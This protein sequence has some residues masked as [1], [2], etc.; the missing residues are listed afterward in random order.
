MKKTIVPGILWGGC[1]ILLLFFGGEQAF[2]RFLLEDDRPSAPADRKDDAAPKDQPQKSEFPPHVAIGI[3]AERIPNV[4]G[5][6]RITWQ[7]DPGATE[8]FIVGRAMEITNTKDKAL[9]AQSIKVVPAAGVNAVIDSNLQPGQYYYVVLSKDRVMSRNIEIYPDVNYTTAPVI[10]EK[11]VEYVQARSYPDQ[12]TLIHGQIINGTQV[13]LTWKAAEESGVV[14]TVYRGE[15]PLNTAE[16]INNAQKLAVITDRR[17]SFIDKTITTTGTYYY[18]VTTRDITGREDLRLVPD[19]SYLT[20]GVY[21]TFKSQVTVSALSAN[22]REG[23]TVELAWKGV[24]S[25]SHRY[26]I[27]RY[28]RPISNPQLLALATVVD[29]IES[30]QTRYV[31]RNPGPGEHYYAVLVKMNNS[32]LDNTLKEGE[33]YTVKPVNLKRQVA[34]ARRRPPDE[35]LKDRPPRIMPATDSVDAIL[36]ES[37][38]RGHYRV[39]IKRLH[40]I[41][42]NS[43]NE[44]ETAKAKLFIGRSLVELKRYRQAIRYLEMPEVRKHYPREAKFWQ[45]YAISRVR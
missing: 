24:D 43:D 33:N 10:I 39:A 14:Y 17:E 30:L 37:F 20:T 18:A 2:P 36:K 25:K 23:K 27:Y 3:R 35:E 32:V 34:Q 5:A 28:S 31:D 6:V 40:N 16:K 41:V 45:E 12:V 7:S 29:S 38:F 42:R 44:V 11:D 8:D 21:V 19:Q 26:V 4:R 13:L 1:I 9:G 22:V 15:S